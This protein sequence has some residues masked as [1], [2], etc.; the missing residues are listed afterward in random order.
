M[1]RLIVRGGTLTTRRTPTYTRTIEPVER[2]G[3]KDIG[4]T[5]TRSCLD[6]RPIHAHSD[7]RAARPADPF[8][9]PIHGVSGVVGVDVLRPRRDH[10]AR[11]LDVAEPVLHVPRGVTGRLLPGDPY[12]GRVRQSG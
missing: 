1:S 12:C 3:A 10:G 6:D 4:I 2:V 7:D 11:H 5:R 8:H 9:R